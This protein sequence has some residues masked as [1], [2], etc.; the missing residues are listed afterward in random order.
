MALMRRASRA[1]YAGFANFIGRAAV[2]GV[3]S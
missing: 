1:V 3:R 2:A